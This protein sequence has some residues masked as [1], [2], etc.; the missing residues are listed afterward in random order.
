MKIS[1]AIALIDALKPNSYTDEEKVDWLSELDHMVRELVIDV[2]EG[3]PETPFEKY[4]IRNVDAA[5]KEVVL[6]KD[7][8]V[9]E[10]F[11]EIYLSWLESKV[12]YYNRETLSYNNTITR[13]NDTFAAYS[14]W[15]NRKHMP[16]GRRIVYY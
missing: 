7:L 11:D 6:A 15:Y 14:N 4:S 5:T 10:P 1:E 13:F 8:I 12:D 2:H 3:A 9:D 16:L